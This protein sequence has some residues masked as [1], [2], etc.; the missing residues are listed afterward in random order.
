MVTKLPISGIWFRHWFWTGNG[1]C[2]CN[3]IV[4][5]ESARAKNGSYHL[6]QK[7]QYLWGM[8]KPGMGLVLEVQGMGGKN[9]VSTVLRTKSD[10][11]ASTKDLLCVNRAKG[12][13]VQ[14]GKG[15]L[16]GWLD[17]PHRVQL[18]HATPWSV[19]ACMDTI[20][21]RVKIKFTTLFHNHHYRQT[22]KSQGEM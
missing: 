3:S 14:A 16:S 10:W 18:T 20:S 7:L 22:K 17:P 5:Q 21:P 4:E 6:A 19:G 9:G 1:C 15:L 13:R 12:G 2:N 8:E 11:G